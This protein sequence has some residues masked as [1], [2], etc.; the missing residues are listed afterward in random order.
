MNLLV[1]GLGL[2]VAVHLIPCVP[3]LRAA[4]VAHLGEMPY[5][6]AFAFLA[7][8]GLVM[9]GWGFSEAPFEPVYEPLGWGRQ[10]AWIAV[11][12]ALVLFAAANLPTHLRTVLRHP[13]LL[14]LLLWALA[15]LA[16]TGDL[17]SVVFFGGFAGYAVLA[18]VGAVARGKQPAAGKT[19]RLAMDAAAVLGGLVAAGL[20]MGF[21]AALFGVPAM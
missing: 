9:A 14:G 8:A 18:I 13:M 4:L 17:R 2:F 19:P 5:R 21:H 3:P 1:A 20:L 12:V 7:L 11:P 10:A 6:A 15:H 16:A